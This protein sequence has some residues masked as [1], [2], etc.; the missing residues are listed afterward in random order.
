MMTELMLADAGA[1]D[2]ML[3][4]SVAETMALLDE[5]MFDVAIFDRQLC[6]G[7]SYPAAVLAKERGI[8]VIIATGSHRPDLPVELGDAI[9]L[10]KPFELTKLELA[11][12][13]ALSR[14][15]RG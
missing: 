2:I 1:R 10:P 11:V 13:E 7:I 9:L 4:G 12:T 8:V 14:R 6:D 3:A 15:S 5:H